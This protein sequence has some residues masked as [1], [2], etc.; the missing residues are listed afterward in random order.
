MRVLKLDFDKP[1]QIKLLKAYF[2]LKYMGCKVFT[3]STRKGWHIYAILP[4]D[5]DLE[6]EL[7]LRMLLGDDEG[8][9]FFDEIREKL[10]L[11]DWED[12]LFQEKYI[13]TKKGI[14][15]VHEEISA[16]PLYEPFYLKR[17]R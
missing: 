10:G 1:T 4:R 9:I 3:F 15:K 2:Y 13:V 7:R 14:K 17:T 12:T 8:R 6:K 5:I 11:S 16:N